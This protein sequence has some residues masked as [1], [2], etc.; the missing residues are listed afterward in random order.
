MS[1]QRANGPTSICHWLRFGLHVSLLCLWFSSPINAG[2]FRTW[3]NGGGDN[4]WFNAANWNP[5]GVP[6]TDDILEIVSG[7]PATLS[8]VTITNEGSILLANGATSA[9]LG[10]L[11]VGSSSNGSLK[12]TNDATLTSS[13]TRIG[14]NEAGY[15][16]AILS[17]AG[18]TW[19]T[20]SNFHIGSAG[21]GTLLVTGGADLLS[22]PTSAS[23]VVAIG[24]FSTGVG[25]VTVQGIGSQWEIS[26]VVLQVGAEGTGRLDILFDAVVATEGATI[27]ASGPSGGSGIVNVDGQQT[28]WTNAG[29]VTVGEGGTGQVLVTAGADVTSRGLT[30]GSLAGSVGVVDVI[31]DSTSWQQDVNLLNPYD[32]VIGDAGEGTLRVGEGAFVTA[33]LFPLG[34]YIGDTVIGNQASGI[35]QLE[36]SGEG[37][38]FVAGQSLVVGASGN[39]KLFATQGGR[40]IAE[41][42]VVGQDNASDNELFVQNATLEASSIVVGQ[43][44]SGELNVHGTGGVSAQNVILGHSASGHGNLTVSGTMTVA[45]TLQIGSVGTGQTTVS[46]GGLLEAGSVVLGANGELEV[47]N[48]TLRT[49]NFENTA[50]GLLDFRGTIEIAGGLANFGT[51]S[52]SF[53]HATQTP[54]WQIVDG[55]RTEYQFSWQI[56]TAAGQSGITT[57]DGVAGGIR[58]TLIATGGGGG[59]DVVVGVAGN[60]TLNVLNGAL[61]D[62]GDDLFVGRNNG[63]TGTLLVS[64]VSDGLRATVDVSRNNTTTNNIYVGGGESSTAGGTGNLLVTQGALVTTSGDATF[65]HLAGSS[66]SVVVGGEML[67]IA[68]TLHAADDVHLGGSDAGAGG[69]GVAQVDEGG[70]IEVGDLLKVWANGSLVVDGGT[71]EARIIEVVPTGQFTINHGL[72]TAETV[73]ATGGFYFHGGVLRVEGGTLTTTP[74]FSLGGSGVPRLELN[75][76]GAT[77]STLSVGT[78]VGDAAIEITNGSN[79]V[80]ARTTLSTHASASGYALVADVGTTWTLSNSLGIGGFGSGVVDVLRGA[81]V[82]VPAATIA[83]NVGSSGTMYVA[84]QGSLVSVTNTFSIG[85]N[86]PGQLDLTDGGT[87]VVKNGSATASLNIGSQGTVGI[88]NNALLDVDNLTLNSGGRMQIDEGTLA[89]RAGTLHPMASF[90]FNSGVLE[91]TG[92]TLTS[93]TLVSIPDDGHVTGMGNLLAPLRGRQG[94]TIA[95]TGPLQ[96]GD[97]SSFLGFVH[98]G[99]TMVGSHTLTLHSAGFAQLGELTTMSPTGAIIAPNGIVLGGGDNFSGAGQIQARLVAASGSI[100]QASGGALEIGDISAADGFVSDGVLQVGSQQVTLLDANEAVLGP[101]TTLGSAGVAGM[102]AV[103]NGLVLEF[104]KNIAGFGTVNSP[105]NPLKPFINNGSI[106]GSSVAEPITLT[107]YVKGVGTLDNVVITGTDAPG[108]SPATVVRGSIEYDGA[109]QIEIEGTGAGEFDRI[110]HLLGAGVADLGGTLEVVADADV[111]AQ[112]GDTI[113][114][115]YAQGGIFNEFE[116]VS[117]PLLDGG[118]ALRL[119]YGETI[120]GLEVILAGDYNADGRVDAADYTVW[121]DLL[122]S[123]GTFLAAD[124]NGDLDVDGDDYAVWRSNFGNS[125]TATLNIGGNVPEPSTTFIILAAICCVAPRLV[126]QSVAI[127]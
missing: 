35:G 104:G 33:A 25:H 71:V 56:G 101:L 75:G 48:G 82:S 47:A 110:E 18:S 34:G 10:N 105:D 96:L 15:G 6:A 27:G 122:G 55:G 1:K 16:T 72:V 20:T 127:G 76:S 38:V 74:A 99:Q 42:I 5:N 107:G 13:D 24:R 85:T 60:G 66:G 69:V 115:L 108:F 53:G 14:F 29:L 57:V 116:T 32:V 28:T 68:A 78:V 117:L 89:I 86:G 49:T 100:I 67:G 98:A 36:V 39:G 7:T 93:P 46:N 123:T 92:G 41:S 30:I 81:T 73:T 97:A 88:G 54:H 118:R 2:E 106:T 84:D 61:V 126:R 19:T 87:V 80:T 90:V 17:E 103:P 109:L 119:F 114:F 59:A 102:L 79:L 51:S 58:S 50:G 22:Q 12:V 112:I 45:D 43:T 113:L 111:A 44:G 21:T 37:T 9:A 4:N 62:S 120:V 70:R 63:A 95:P 91:L 40:V 125:I 121:R 31:G 52:F 65:G 64:G 8:Q 83:G 77:I 94:T 11:F 3:T 23:H 124:G 26:D